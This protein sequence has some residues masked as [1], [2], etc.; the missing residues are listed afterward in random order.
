MAANSAPCGE[1]YYC[2]RE[3]E[4]LCTICCS[5]TAPTPNTSASRSALSAKNLHHV[6]DHVGYQDAA[7]AEPLAC[8]HARLEESD[9]RPGD[10]VAVIGPGPHRNHVRAP[11]QGRVWRARDRRSDAASRSWIARRAWAP[12]S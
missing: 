8:V 11:G 10:T 2:S 4:N 5:I 3:Q 12:M 1:C 9:L 7:L 6:D